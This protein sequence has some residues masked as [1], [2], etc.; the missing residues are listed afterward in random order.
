MTKT[1]SDWTAGK[2]TTYL[3]V[4]QQFQSG[5]FRAKRSTDPITVVVGDETT[6]ERY[7]NGPLGTKT[8]YR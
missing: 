4:V 1:Y 5:A 7:V 3:A 6:W 8:S 2:T